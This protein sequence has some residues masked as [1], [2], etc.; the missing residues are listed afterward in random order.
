VWGVNDLVRDAH[1]GLGDGRGRK[2]AGSL[3]RSAVAE[4][5]AGSHVCWTTVEAGS[6]EKDPRGPST[7]PLMFF[8]LFL[9]SIFWQVVRNLQW[10]LPWDFIVLHAGCS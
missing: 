5:L 6:A 4:G 10:G 8:F 9:L 1:G 3:L 2:W 7:L